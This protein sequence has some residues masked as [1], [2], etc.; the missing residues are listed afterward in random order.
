MLLTT[1]GAHMSSNTSAQPTPDPPSGR[2]WRRRAKRWALGLLCLV[3]LTYG[4]QALVVH[5]VAIDTGS[6]ELWGLWDCDA[7]YITEGRPNIERV[8]CMIHLPGM[9]LRHALYSPPAR[10]GA[11]DV[12]TF[13]MG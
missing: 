9:A 12:H 4:A 3:A 8:G 5:K 10:A 1:P 7:S 13:M 2:G 11:V 6:G